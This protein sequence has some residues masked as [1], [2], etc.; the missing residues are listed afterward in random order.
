MHRWRPWKLSDE[1]GS[2]S[3]EF[4]TLGTLLIVPLAYLMLTL[5]ALQEASIAGE[6]AARSAARVLAADPESS[7][8]LALAE[9]TIG[10]ATSDHGFESN[11]VDQRVHC[12]SPTSACATPGSIISVTVTIAVPLP[13]APNLTGGAAPISIPTSSTSSFAV[14]RFGLSA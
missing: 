11:A 2:A 3:L 5:S 6:S 1:R 7:E 4:L 9:A 8:L 10:L 13:F 14:T 12:S